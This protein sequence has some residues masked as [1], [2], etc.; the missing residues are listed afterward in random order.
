M[1]AAGALGRRVGLGSIAAKESTVHTQQG[2]LLKRSS[3][4][5]LIITA[6]YDELFCLVEWLTTFCRVCVRCARKAYCL[7]IIFLF[8]R[9]LW[10]RQAVSALFTPS[11]CML[12]SIVAATSVVHARY[13]DATL[14]GHGGQCCFFYR[15]S[16]HRC[17]PQAPPPP[18][19][20][21]T[22]LRPN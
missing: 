18:L 17:R 4:R 13:S 2:G 15:C 21:L 11:V 19:L 5:E 14:D 6:S 9:V 1:C 10:Y 20:S 22:C 8:F 7:S 16:L 12:L 3:I